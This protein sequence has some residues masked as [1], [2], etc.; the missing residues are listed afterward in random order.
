M[1]IRLVGL[2]I[3]LVVGCGPATP[4]EEQIRAEIRGMAK[5]LAD[6][7]VRGVLSPV[8]DDFAGV[9]WDL[10]RR[11]ARLLLLREL[12]AYQQ[13][14]ARVFDI[15]VD[16]RGEERAVATMQVVLTGGSGLIPDA[17]RWYRVDTGWRREGSDW[18]LVSAEWE[19]VAGRR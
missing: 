4:A 1:T 7:D 3:L 17:G 9:T 16:M 12:R 15:D 5:A 6:G 19:A 8:S 10:D 2:V 11:G 14:R 13:L 18:K